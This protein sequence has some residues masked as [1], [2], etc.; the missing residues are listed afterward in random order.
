MPYKRET[1][2]MKKPTLFAVAAKFEWE[3]ADPEES[4]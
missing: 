4:M 2:V 1:N 3:L